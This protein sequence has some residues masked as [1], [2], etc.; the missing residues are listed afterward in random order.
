[1]YFRCCSGVEV[2]SV[3]SLDRTDRPRLMAAGRRGHTGQTAAVP[4]GAG[5]LPGRGSA[6]NHCEYQF[7]KIGKL[8]KV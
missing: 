2:E 8:N 7:K 5:S 6:I 4:V 3:W 1:M